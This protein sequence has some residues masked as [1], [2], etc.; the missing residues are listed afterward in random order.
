MAEDEGFRVR[1]WGAWVFSSFSGQSG[2]K[3]LEFPKSFYSWASFK[4]GCLFGALNSKTEWVAL[5]FKGLFLPFA[6]VFVFSVQRSVALFSS[7]LALV[8]LICYLCS[9][10]V[11]WLVCLVWSRL[12]LVWCDLCVIGF[13]LVWLNFM[14]MCLKMHGSLVKT[15]KAFRECQTRAL[16]YPKRYPRGFWSTAICDLFGSALEAKEALVDQG[17]TGI[18]W[19]PWGWKFSAFLWM[20]KD[21]PN[22]QF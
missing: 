6:S 18:G 1:A 7:P 22:L 15:P 3:S 21:S 17:A 20:R 2:L 10:F 11:S 14:N 5:R 16:W 8:W 13:C 19:K 4:K 9:L 12:S